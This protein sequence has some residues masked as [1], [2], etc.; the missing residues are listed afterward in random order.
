MLVSVVLDPSAFDK[1]CFDKVYRIHTEDCLKGVRKNGVLIVDSKTNIL[2]HALLRKAESLPDKEMESRILLEEL[3]K[4]RNRRVVEWPVT[5]NTT[6]SANLLDLAYYLK[7]KTGSDALIVGDDSLQTLKSEAKYDASIVP[8]SEYRDSNFEKD[9]Q[10][11]ENQVG[12]IDMLPKKEVDDLIIG[13]VRFTK[14]VRFYDAYIGSG[15]NTSRFRKGIEHILSLWHDNG[16]FSRQK[17]ICNVEIYTCCAAQIRDDEE[18]HAKENKR[19]RNQDSHR[20]VIRELIEP[21]KNKY[22]NWQIKL[23]VKDDPEGIFHARHL[24]TQHAIVRVDKGFDLFK[25]NGG[26]RRNFFTLNMAEGAHLR[27]CRDL[28]DADL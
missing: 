1:D 26:F 16:L 2:R 10:K 24:E 25:P 8:L 14:W 13:A 6:S 20:K 18:N 27:E 3:L 19:T 23:S 15:E 17:G 5:L 9:R 28:Q 4:N 12:A 7:T 22:P 21:L 11:Y